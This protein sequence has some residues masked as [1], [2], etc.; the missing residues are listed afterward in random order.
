M[1][2][3]MTPERAEAPLAEIPLNAGGF[4]FGVRVYPSGHPAG[5]LLVWA[6]GGAFMFGDLEMPEAH[7]VAMELSRSGVVVV[8]VDYTLAPLDGLA[9]LPLPEAAGEDAVPLIDLG[10]D[11][12]PR[13]RFPVA[14]LQVVAAVEWARENAVR[15]RADPDAVFV[16]GASAGGNLAAGA[17]LRLRDRGRPPAGL[18]LAY[19][20]LHHTLPPADDELRPMLPG[21][22]ELLRFA[23]PE[24]HVMTAGY[25]AGDVDDAY[26]FPGGHD[27]RGLPPT[28]V[29]NSDVDPIRMSGQAFAADLAMAGVDVSVVRERGTRHGH[30]NDSGSPGALRSV[31]RIAAWLTA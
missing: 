11:R 10:R 19:P 23:P 16:G 29:V 21:L 14:S 15:L 31:T 13:A 2:E 20:V 7:W 9:S 6:H 12:G 4:P 17:A 24:M 22:P 28:L 8:S 27:A 26:A 18:V 30:L 3:F 1:E 25:A 5:P